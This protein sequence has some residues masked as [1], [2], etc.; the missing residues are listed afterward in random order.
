MRRI[1]ES[2]VEEAALEWFE[3]LKWT[4]LHGPDIT[5]DGS[6]PERESYSDV[7]L[8]GRLEAAIDSLNPDLPTA[9]KE[10]ALRKVLHI[11]SPSPFPD[12]SQPDVP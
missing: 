9:A 6:M 3:A 1:T 7:I 11:D 8:P 5:F 2:H 12:S 10:E 4:V